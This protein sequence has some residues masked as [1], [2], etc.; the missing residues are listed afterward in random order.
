MQ[1]RLP[2]EHAEV[3]GLARRLARADAQSAPDDR[4][5]LLLYW[6]GTGAT[7]LSSEEHVLLGA[8]ER[9]GGA[10][11]PLNASIRA[12][13]ARLGAAVAAIAADPRPGAHRLRM[14]G[15]DLSAHVRRQDHELAPIV[16]RHLP[17]VEL[18]GVAAE[19]EAVRS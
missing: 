3:S 8:W 14:I 19:L 18:A 11:H 12:E 13:H 5:A 17:P 9:H 2:I 4:R 16:E 10:D 1:H 6:Y 7:H 15:R